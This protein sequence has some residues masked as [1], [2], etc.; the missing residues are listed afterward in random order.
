MQASSA[1]IKRTD[2]EPLQLVKKEKVV[3][4]EVTKGKIKRRG[5]KK[6]DVK[7]IKMSASSEAGS[8]VAEQGKVLS[9]SETKV[10]CKKKGKKGEIQVKKQ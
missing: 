2:S 10:T 5:N 8:S 7:R 6:N 4:L 9:T 3:C 1:G